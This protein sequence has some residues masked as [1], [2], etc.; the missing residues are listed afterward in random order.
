MTPDTI[1]CGDS[2]ELLKTW[3]EGFVDLVF[4]DPPF[5]IGYVYDKYNDD[6]PDELVNFFSL[7]LEDQAYLRHARREPFSRD[8]IGDR[9]A[10]ARHA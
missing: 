8:G 4:A 3:P 9:I 1:Y 5:N 10:N 7:G 2:I 6:R